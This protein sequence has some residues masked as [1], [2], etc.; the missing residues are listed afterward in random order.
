MNNDKEIHDLIKEQFAKQPLPIQKAITSADLQKLL[1]KLAQEYKLHLDKWQILENQ[2][3]L[4]LLGFQ[5][6]S[7]LASSIHNEVELSEEESVRLAD[8]IALQVFEPI[9]KE[10]ERILEH[11]E[12]EEKK[13][14]AI[15][16]MTAQVLAQSESHDDATASVAAPISPVV[17]TSSS[18]ADLIQTPSAA[19][20]SQETEAVPSPVVTRGSISPTYTPGAASTERAA[21]EGDPYR[22]PVD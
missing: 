18:P 19:A 13:E 10:L 16:G 6:A 22:E 8:A 4:T 1:R 2:V 14:T 17:D 3:T 21:V 12:A 15:E 5:P 20:T 11:P 7:E 9:R